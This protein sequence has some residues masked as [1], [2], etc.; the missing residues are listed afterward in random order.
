MNLGQWLLRFRTSGCGWLLILSLLAIARPAWAIPVDIKTSLDA[1]K[2]R[3]EIAASIKAQVADLEGD[4]PV[5]RSKA[6]DALITEVNAPGNQPYSGVFLDVYAQELNTQL[7]PLTDN[8]DTRVRLNVA[9]IVAKVGEK[10]DSTRLFDITEKLLQDKSPAVVNWAL[11][12]AKVV[13]PPLLQAGMQA[14]ATKLTTAIK[15]HAD[16]AQLLPLVYDALAIRFDA[17]AAAPNRDKMVVAVVPQ[18][19]ELLQARVKMYIQQVPPEPTDIVPA[20]LFLSDPRTWNALGRENQQPL[21]MQIVQ[22]LSDLIGLAGQRAV[23]ATAGRSDL[24]FVIQRAASGLFAIALTIK[25]QSVQDGLAPLTKIT[26]GGTNSNLAQL[27]ASVPAV[28]KLYPAWAAIKP[29]PAIQSNSP[30]TGP[31][32][33]TAPAPAK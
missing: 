23:T 25:E 13:L 12:A 30:T 24:E 8:K 31:T 6:R 14:N 5:K 16:D 3:E 9:I 4:D 10:V 26:P 2:H 18:M 27:S 22:T 33:A 20:V 29:A 11:K 28:L 15:A 32:T 21:Q 17:K 19:L 1:D 7:M